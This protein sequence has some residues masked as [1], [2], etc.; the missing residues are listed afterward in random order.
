MMACEIC[1]KFFKKK[2]IANHLKSCR[3]KAG[4]SSSTESAS[5]RRLSTSLP[6]KPAKNSKTLNQ[7][8]TN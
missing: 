3:I 1:G 8:I 4:F 6:L 7:V 2:S 5:D